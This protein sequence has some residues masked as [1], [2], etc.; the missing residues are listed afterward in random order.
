MDNVESPNASARPRPSFNSNR[1]CKGTT[2]V[3]FLGRK[4]Y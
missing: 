3:G 2:S 1:K 4:K